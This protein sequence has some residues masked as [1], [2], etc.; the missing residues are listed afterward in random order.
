MMSLMPTPVI[1]AISGSIVL[2]LLLPAAT[3]FARP[4]YKAAFEEAF[5]A[6]VQAV[7]CAFCHPA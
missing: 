6:A 3:S 4:Q 5:P 1:R 2:M 7:T